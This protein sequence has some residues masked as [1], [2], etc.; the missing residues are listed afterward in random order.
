[1]RKEK[2]CLVIWAENS[3]RISSRRARIVRRPD[4][5]VER[6]QHLLV[7]STAKGEGDDYRVQ[8]Y[9]PGA[10]A[11]TRNH[12]G[13]YAGEDGTGVDRTMRFHGKAWP[14]RLPDGGMGRRDTRRYGYP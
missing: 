4:K 9:G 6:I 5:V 12:S 14:G 10:S 8:R 11:P 13:G 3:D 1:M 2:S 7:G